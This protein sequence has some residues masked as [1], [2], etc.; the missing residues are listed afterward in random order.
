MKVRLKEYCFAVPSPCY[1]YR[2]VKSAD[3]TRIY[4]VKARTIDGAK[5]W[6]S[7]SLGQGN[8][9]DGTIQVTILNV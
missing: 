2:G 8:L 3:L 7:L 4:R 6:L 1:D 9:P 5:R